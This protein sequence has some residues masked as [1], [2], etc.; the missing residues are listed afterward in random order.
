MP[1][2]A[3][4][5]PV[6]AAGA[7]RLRVLTFSSLFPSAARP[8]HGIFVETRLRHLL[9][10]GRIDARVIAPVPWFPLRLPVFGNYARM[11][12]TPRSDLRADGLRVSYPRYFMLPK[13]GVA[14]Q[15]RA[16]A[17]A[18]AS[19]L[20]PWLEEGWRPDLI[21][22]HYFYPDGVAAAHLADRLGLPFVITARGTDVN[23]I[24]RLPGPGRRV[25]WAA[26]RAAAVVA[27]SSR[28]AQA[29]V[30]LGVEASKVVVLRNGVDTDVFFPRERAAARAALGLRRRV[31]LLC[32]GNLVPEKGFDLAIDLLSSVEDAELLIVG[33]GPQRSVLAERARSQ[34]VSDRVHF[35]G[36]MPQA[37]LAEVYSAADALLLCS[38]REGWPNVVLESLAC[39]TP[40]VAADVGAVAEMLTE[41]AVGRIV[42][43]RDWRDFRAALLDMLRQPADR[44]AI[45]RHAAAFDWASVSRGQLD[46]FSGALEGAR[47]AAPMPC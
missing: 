8:R 41:P 23:V 46:V 3:A 19:A 17:W 47:D 38:T 16:M 34:G 10:E 33:E 24:A 7:G 12:A 35:A 22:A 39:G 11:S 37:R 32:V 40:V 26:R 1:A 42:P 6:P 21:D 25:L 9:R 27:V 31:V 44:N 36:S 45:V 18:G 43:A 15:P 13:V 5:S 20:Q 4:A 14:L 28:L 29:L 2:E 30:D